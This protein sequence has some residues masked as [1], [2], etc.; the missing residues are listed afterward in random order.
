VVALSGYK[1]LVP[2]NNL[3]G[4]QA[5]GHFSEEL[6]SACQDSNHKSLI[7]QPIVCISYILIS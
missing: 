5:A 3:S 1:S 4:H 7:I 6:F 2:M